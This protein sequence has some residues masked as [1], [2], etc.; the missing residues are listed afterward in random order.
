MQDIYCGVGP[1]IEDGIDAGCLQ[2]EEERER[3]LTE[4]NLSVDN[5]LPR[6]GSA[7]ETLGARALAGC[8]ASTSVAT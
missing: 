4:L 1:Y 5:T 3:E 6:K 8:L 2:D 7:V